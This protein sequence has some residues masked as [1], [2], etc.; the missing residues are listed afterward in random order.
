MA[1]CRSYF[2]RIIRK[3]TIR[4]GLNS[5]SFSGHRPFHFAAISPQIISPEGKGRSSGGLYNIICV[6]TNIFS[7]NFPAIFALLTAGGAFG[8]ARSRFQLFRICIESIF[9]KHIGCRINK[10]KIVYYCI[11]MWFYSINCLYF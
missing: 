10:N 11:F 1:V 6:Y 9:L 5:F 2:G 7:D 3:K 8:S 4:R